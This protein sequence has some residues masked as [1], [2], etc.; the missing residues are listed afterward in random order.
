MQL[1]LDDVEAHAP[2]VLH[3]PRMNDDEFYAFCQRY[4]NFRIERTA[5]GEV[6]IMPPTGGETSYRNSDLN[7]QLARWTKR[8]KRGIAFE[9]N[10]EFMLPSGAARS[11]DAS[12]VLRS[13]LDKLTKS[14]KRKFL[15]LCPDFVVE[16]TSPT[17][18]LKQVKTKMREWMENGAQL[19]WLLDPDRTTAYI[20]RPGQEP[21]ELVN[22]PKLAGESPVKGF[23]LNLT[24]IWAGL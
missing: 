2:I 9:S 17:D 8:D 24:D 21:E 6:I 13:R 18:R 20:Y 22:P 14:Q 7:Y 3:P 19:A 11:P 23:T 5:K 12:W 16:L 15:R 1:V 10:V 4:P